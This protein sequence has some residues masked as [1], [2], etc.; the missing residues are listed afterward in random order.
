MN[1]HASY[2]HVSV[3]VSDLERARAFYGDRLGLKEI[4]RPAFD[5]PGV[6]YELDG[7]IAL[8]IMVAKRPPARVAH[9]PFDVIYPH[10]ALWTD[11]AD[12]TCARLRAEGIEVRDFVS[13]PTGLRQ[14]FVDD[15]DGNRVEFIGPTRAPRVRRMEGDE[16]TGERR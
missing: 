5:F 11:D 7:N 14:L 15:P 9:Q 4:P 16:P 3:C 2:H 12:L 6:W 10:F 13:T 8:H 1:L